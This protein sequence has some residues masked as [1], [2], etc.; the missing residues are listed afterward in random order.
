MTE[1]EFEAIYEALAYAVDDLGPEKSELYL[2]KVALALA[3]TVGDAPRVLA[4]LDECKTGL[5][6][7]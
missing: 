2:A 6:P 7:D 1:V 3:E 5:D 4:V